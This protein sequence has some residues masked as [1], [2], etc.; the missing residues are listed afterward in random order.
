MIN[1]LP[2]DKKAEIR[3]ART[4]TIIVRYIGILLAAT[5]FSLGVLYVSHSILE[6]TM[7]SAKSRLA[8]VNSQPSSLG[9]VDADAQALTQK[10][11]ESKHVLDQEVR[12]SKVL[13]KLG[14]A[15]PKNTILDAVEF[16]NETFMSTPTVVK[17]YAKSAAD[18]TTL[19][20]VLRSSGVFSS[21]TVQST[22]ATAGIDGYP[23]SVTL[24]GV[25]SKEGAQ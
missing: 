17:V 19:A 4:N 9:Q 16:T 20:Q 12:Y 11:S 24:T 7:Q 5:L 23:V 6:Q 14:Q 25:F 13:T 2:S 10:L 18:T 15:M 3:A 8:A 21:I 1:L 22:D